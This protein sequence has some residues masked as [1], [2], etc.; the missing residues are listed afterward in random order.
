MKRQQ[1]K[2]IY[3]SS[4]VDWWNRIVNDKGIL[5]GMK[6]CTLPEK[7]LFEP[8]FVLLCNFYLKDM[9]K[10]VMENAHYIAGLLAQ[11]KNEKNDKLFAEQLA[12]RR[13]DGS[14][15]LLISEVRFRRLMGC[16]NLKEL[17]PFMRRIIAQLNN[18]LNIQSFCEDLLVWQYPE[19]TR[20][21]WALKYYTNTID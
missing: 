3:A 19:W 14:N 6:H 16:K 5:A 20:K 17:Y 11:V 12:Q 9:D 15:D 10:N 7:I 2:K 4:F 1:F 21:K 18:E 8:G 13:K